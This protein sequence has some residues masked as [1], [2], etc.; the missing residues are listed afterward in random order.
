MAL[1]DIVTFLMCRFEY[2]QAIERSPM[3]PPLPH[4]P[5]SH[6]FGPDIIHKI[7]CN[8]SQSGCCYMCY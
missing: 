7:P 4:L 8:S 2:A 1:K 5:H 6:F 3:D